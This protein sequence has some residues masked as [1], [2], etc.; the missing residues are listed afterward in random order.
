MT[1]SKSG[2]P[3]LAVALLAALVVLGLASLGGQEVSPP[4]PPRPTPAAAATLGAQSTA[5]ESVPKPH[6]M[7]PPAEGSGLMP[8]D[9]ELMKRIHARFATGDFGGALT[10]ADALLGDTQ[11]QPSPALLSWLRSQLPALLISAGWSK[12]RLGD[13]D[14]AITLLTRAEAFG[15]KP[16][17]SRGLAL[18]HYRRGQMA[19]ARDAFQ[20]YLEQAPRDGAMAFL[21][22]DVL[23]SE[24]RFDEAVKLLT[25]LKAQASTPAPAAPSDAPSPAAIDQRLASMSGR[26]DESPRQQLE[27]SAHFRLAFRAG[28]YEDLV[29][30]VLQTLELALEEFTESYGLRPPAS[31]LEVTLYPAANFGTLGGGPSWAEGL[32]DGRLRIPIRAAA[33]AAAAPGSIAA[34]PA[35]SELEVVLRHELVHGLLAR[36]TESRQLPPW[37]EEGLAQRLS[38]AGRP[39]GTFAFGPAPGGLLPVAAL[40]TPFISLPAA[41]A[42]RAYQQSLFIILELETRYGDHALRRLISAVTPTSAT[43]SDGLLSPLGVKMADLHRQAAA[44]WELRRLPAPP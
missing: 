18:C 24:G 32:F 42:S 7:S 34:A 14:N 5:L 1:K 4:A 30:Q 12:L 19:P 25:G 22:A 38:C 8:G 26:A 16:E 17:S 39:C 29:A 35:L 6:T 43:T 15:R 40:E 2:L 10:L 20:A 11:A 44:D 36:M 41:S 3:T 28:D 13:C 23:E 21:Y 27:T 31:P 33:V 9:L 37:W